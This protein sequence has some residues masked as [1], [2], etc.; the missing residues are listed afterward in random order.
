MVG[1]RLCRCAKIEFQNENETRN[2]DDNN[3]KAKTIRSQTRNNGCRRPSWNSTTAATLASLAT[4]S[5]SFF[6]GRVSFFFFA[7][8]ATPPRTHWTMEDETGFFFFIFLFFFEADPLFAFGGRG[9]VF[10][11]SFCVRSSFFFVSPAPDRKPNQTRSRN[12]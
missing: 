5:F 8:H 7:V 4:V 12:G 10:R 6:Y 1:G 3:K 2:N 9:G 11:V